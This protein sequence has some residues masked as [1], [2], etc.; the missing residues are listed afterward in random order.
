MLCVFLCIQ[1]ISIKKIVFVNENTYDKDVEE[2]INEY[3]NKSLI[4]NKLNKPINYINENIKKEFYYYEW[5]NI[6]KR[7]NKLLI[8]I[9]KQDE[10]SYIDETS[11]IPGDIVS[12]KNGIIKYY[13]IKKGVNLIKD[14]QSVLKNDILISGNLKYY[15]EGKIKY[16]HPV[17]I[18]LAEVVDTYNIKVNKVNKEFIR[19]GNIDI[20]YQRMIFNYKLNAKTNFEYYDEEETKIIDL[21]IYKKIKITYYEVKEV[22]STLN[23]E[24]AERYSY[25]LIEKDFNE[26][27]VHNKEHIIASHI[28]NFYED[29]NFYY[30]KYIVKKLE[31]ICEFKAVKLEDS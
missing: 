23:K 17:G 8:I 22:I 1:A 18:I 6:E 28:S 24:E 5:I 26:N 27:K 29:D 16:I 25:S 15:N 4:Y 13:Y 21:K 3:I 12:K 9:D 10:K 20:K 2:Y 19:T 30:Y 31:N 11:N 14:N 7:G